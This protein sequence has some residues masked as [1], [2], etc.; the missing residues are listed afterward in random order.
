MLGGV[1]F[2]TTMEQTLE[3]V[4]QLILDWALFIDLFA[5]ALLVMTKFFSN[6]TGTWFG[7]GCILL[8]I[9]L[10]NASVM[11]NMDMN[12]AQFLPTLFGLVV[13]GALGV[14]FIGNWLLDGVK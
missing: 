3:I 4:R 6:T 13:L 5:V 14:R 10:G 7:V 1:K 11:W 9:A 8:I 2:T 12:P